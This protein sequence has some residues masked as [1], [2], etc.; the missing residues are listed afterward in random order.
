MLYR[1]QPSRTDRDGNES[2]VSA[3]QAAEALFRPHKPPTPTGP[4]LVE[5][6]TRKPRVLRA[7]IPARGAEPADE[8]PIVLHRDHLVRD[9]AALLGQQRELEARLGAI[10]NELRA[11][12]IYVAVRNGEAPSLG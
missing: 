2:V 5:P 7:T 12:D 3:R 8:P 4:P 10:D 1:S 9:R 6:S 11:I